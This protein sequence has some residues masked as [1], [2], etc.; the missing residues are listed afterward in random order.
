MF[1]WNIYLSATRMYVISR[2]RGGTEETPEEV[3]EMAG[4]TG[5]IYTITINKKPNCTCPDNKKGNQCKHIVYV[6]ILFSSIYRPKSAIY[7][8]T[9]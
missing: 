1:A 3:I 5:N 4:S 7:L 2:I 9:F 6:C 8:L